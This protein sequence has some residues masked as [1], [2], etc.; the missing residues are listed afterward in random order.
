M[1][2]WIISCTPALTLVKVIVLYQLVY[3]S[4]IQNKYRV[5]QGK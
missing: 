2:W 4:L 5:Q 1:R 3:H